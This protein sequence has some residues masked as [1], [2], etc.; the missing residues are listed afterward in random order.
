M[1]KRRPGRSRERNEVCGN[2][3][4][5]VERAKEW[6][7]KVTQEQFL[8]GT[9]EGRGGKGD[10]GVQPLETRPRLPLLIHLLPDFTLLLLGDPLGP[11]PAPSAS[12]FL[13]TLECA[14]FPLKKGVAGF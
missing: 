4:L 10:D 14:F 8:R 7:W 5:G 9:D 6:A 3:L 11:V 13:S 2:T 12:L 1:S